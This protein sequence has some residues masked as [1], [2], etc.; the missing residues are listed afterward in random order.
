MIRGRL[1]AAA[2]ATA[3]ACLI[4]CAVHHVQP[5]QDGP[6]I[7]PCF[8]SADDVARWS[9]LLKRQPEV[10]RRL[11]GADDET[12]ELER[13]IALVRVVLHDHGDLVSVEERRA[14]W[15]DQQD[16][17]IRATYIREVL[18]AQVEVT[19]AEVR[20]IFTEH[21]DGYRKAPGVKVLEIFKWA[22]EDLSELRSSTRAELDRLAAT[23][24]SV[25]AFTAAARAYS[26]ATNAYRG[27]RIG[28]LHRDRVPAPLQ[29][30]LFD[31]GL[32]L[33]EVVES[34]EG[35]YLFWITATVPARDQDWADAAE[36]I[37]RRL[38]SQ[39]IEQ[40]I[41]DDAARLRQ[42]IEL[43]PPAEHDRGTGAV[44]RVDG[45]VYTAAEL[46]L[47]ERVG[48]SSAVTR[49]L[50]AVMMARELESR[51]IVVDPPD[52]LSYYW[53]LYRTAWP[54]L[55]ERARLRGDAEPCVI[56]ENE[57]AAPLRSK[58]E[59][60]TFDLLEVD[61][62]GS[63]DVLFKVFR[64][65]Y[66]LQAAADLEALRERLDGRFSIASR[67]RHFDRVTSTEAAALGPEIHSTIKQR[68]G[69][70]DLSLPLVIDDQSRIVVI[71]FHDRSIEEVLS[72]ESTRRRD[73]LRRRRAF[74]DCLADWL[75]AGADVQG[76]AE[77]VDRP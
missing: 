27:G 23:I 15:R 76:C 2:A 26:D 21:R 10:R 51:G 28:T 25:D 30:A 56:P 37:R 59:R 62:A 72:T 45:R 36:A 7:V 47:A 34:P 12:T 22:P 35:F 49:R 13:M 75:L 44:A 48:D 69:P 40:L 77:P 53:N 8:V 18:G 63:P 57:D 19:D 38:R 60:W 61:G 4:G 74:E 71:A 20:R 42:R 11:R 43:N 55:V 64:A 16:R 52:E 50:M 14:L 32:G 17:A 65:R 33:T 67:I 68:L 58:V 1:P 31:H 5:Q 73:E 3:A 29:R 24:D 9:A 70:N 6:A 46:E 39:R 54:R 41:R 66:G